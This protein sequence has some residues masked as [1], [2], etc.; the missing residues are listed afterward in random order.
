VAF[1]GKLEEY[2]TR[3]GLKVFNLTNHFNPRDF[4]NNLASASFG[5]F[6]NGVGRMFALKFVIEKK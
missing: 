3:V 1:P 4:Q 2:R 5:A 6:Y